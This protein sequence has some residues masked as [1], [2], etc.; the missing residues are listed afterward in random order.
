MDE[1]WH[2]RGFGGG[3]HRGG[4]G[5][6]A[7]LEPGMV[8]GVDHSRD[9]DHRVGAVAQPVER[10]AVLERAVDPFD[11]VAGRHRPA[12]EGA[13]LVAGVARRVEQAPAD[14]TGRAGDR[15]PHS[16]DQ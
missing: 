11:P 4:A 15:E 3:E 14:E 16:G 9:M 2:S 10:G 5:D 12:R 6:I 13:D 8:A 7:G 1:A